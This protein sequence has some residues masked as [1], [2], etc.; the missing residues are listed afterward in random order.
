MTASRR[1]SDVNK[2]AFQNALEAWSGK[3]LFPFKFVANLDSCGACVP[4][5][6]FNPGEAY[7]T[8]VVFF[9]P[10]DLL[11]YSDALE[12]MLSSSQA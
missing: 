3:Y 2:Q 8:S 1:S 10:E 4:A 6:V 5:I 7:Y 12:T 9:T 11:R